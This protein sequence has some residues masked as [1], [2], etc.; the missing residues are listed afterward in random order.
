MR[1]FEDLGALSD[2]LAGVVSDGPAVVGLL[3]D[4]PTVVI[5]GSRQVHMPYDEGPR[6][7][8]RGRRAAQVSP[9]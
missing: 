3:F 2:G 9:R 4:Y 5:H 8:Q 6:K 7:A 1:S